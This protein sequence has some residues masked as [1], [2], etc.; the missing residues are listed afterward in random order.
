MYEL[1]IRE[2]GKGE[3][4]VREKRERNIALFEHKENHP[5]VSFTKLGKIYGEKE[6][7]MSKQA[8]HHIYQR[9]KKK[10]ASD[11]IARACQTTPVQ[12]LTA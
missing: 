8:A 5:D 7:G 3:R 12:N 4:T 1:S 11:K 10:N 2:K 6:K 9:E